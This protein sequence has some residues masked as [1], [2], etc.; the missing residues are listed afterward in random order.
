MKRLSNRKKGVRSSKKVVTL[1][2]HILT[3][4]INNKVQQFTWEDI[5]TEI[6][7]AH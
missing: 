1:N 6:F 3:W 2:T 7:I 5:T 4:A